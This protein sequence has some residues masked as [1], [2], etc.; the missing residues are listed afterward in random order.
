MIADF[1]GCL[2]DFLGLATT[3]TGQNG[4]GFVDISIRPKIRR[5]IRIFRSY[6]RCSMKYLRERLIANVRDSSHYQRAQ[7]SHLSESLLSCRIS[8][9]GGWVTVEDSIGAACERFIVGDEADGVPG[10]Q[11]M[12]YG[13]GMKTALKLLKKHGRKMQRKTCM[14]SALPI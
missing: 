4:K 12:V 9:S 1:D 13:S 3:I 6:E 14:L 7:I 8:R 2:R 11:H 10:I 5:E